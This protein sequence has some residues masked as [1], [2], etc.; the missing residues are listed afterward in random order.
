MPSTVTPRIYTGAF[1]TIV[2]PIKYAL[3]AASDPLAEVDSQTFSA[4]H[5]IRAVSFPGLDRI[6]YILRVFEMLDG[7]PLRTLVNDFNFNPDNNDVDYKTPEIVI[8]G[9]TPGIEPG[10]TTF[11][12]DGTDGK[13]DWRNW[14]PIVQPPGFSPWLQDYDYT[15]DALTGTFTVINGQ[16]LESEFRMLVEF[17]TKIV[18]GASG[19]PTAKLFSQVLDVNAN[20]TLVPDDFGKKILVN[21]ASTYLKISLP[22]ILTVPP[23]KTIFFETGIDTGTDYCVEI[24]TEGST[25]WT[26]GKAG[27]GSMFMTAGE[28]FTAYRY[29]DAWHVQDA[30]GNYKEVGEQ[31]ASDAEEDEITGAIVMKGQLLSTTQYARLYNDYVLK[32]PAGRAVPFSGPGGWSENPT[33]WSLASGGFFRCPDRRNRHERNADASNLAGAP[34]ADAVGAHQH[35]LFGP[36]AAGNDA[37]DATSGVSLA[38]SDG[39]NLGYRMTKSV[40]ANLASAGLS[41]FNGASENFVK[42]YFINR[43]VKI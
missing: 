39:G 1:P 14:V 13:P 27:R 16:A 9:L 32:L 28:S 36:D 40:A 41:G 37:I 35:L 22:N 25:Q 38:N 30:S 21:P 15:W 34:L 17:E 11:T 7:V 12:F 20:V 6:N 29:G 19:I 26:Y 3:Y 42:S 10:S 33:K 5:P 23:L 18:T 31:F 43:F 4:P 2:N 24:Q 8:V